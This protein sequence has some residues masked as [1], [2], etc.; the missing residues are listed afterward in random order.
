MENKINKAAVR[1]V[2]S[3]GYVVIIDRFH[4]DWIVANNTDGIHFIKVV[5]DEGNMP[6]PSHYLLRH[7]FEHVAAAWLHAVDPDDAEGELHGDLICIN[8]VSDDLGFVRYE[9]DAVGMR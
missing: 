1:I 6:E 7:E 2:E 9:H 3:K 8:V 5:F 4:D